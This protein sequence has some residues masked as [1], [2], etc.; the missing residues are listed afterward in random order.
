[1]SPRERLSGRWRVQDA[2]I[3]LAAAVLG[4]ACAPDN[5]DGRFAPGGVVYLKPPAPDTQPVDPWLTYLSSAEAST[6]ALEMQ[7]AVDS[8]T[9]WHFVQSRVPQ[10][11]FCYQEYG[12]RPQREQTPS[13][14]LVLAFAIDSGGAFRNIGIAERA[15]GWDGVR[16][17]SVE[18][19]LIERAANWKVPHSEIPRAQVRLRIGLR[20]PKGAAPMSPRGPANPSADQRGRRRLPE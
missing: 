4:A 7:P 2:H 10:L 5:A 17:G 16:G 20:A 11:R 6:I 8:A 15:G 18:S 12:V 13:G 3:V 14:Q 1:M 19:C 9:V